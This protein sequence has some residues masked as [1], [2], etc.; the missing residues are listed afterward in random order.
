MKLHTISKVVVPLLHF[1]EL[2]GK[3]SRVFYNKC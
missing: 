3:R 2:H 1:K